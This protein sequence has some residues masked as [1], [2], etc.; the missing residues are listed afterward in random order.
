MIAPG[1]TA[2]ERLLIREAREDDLPAIVE[3][4]RGDEKGRHGDRDA[5]V[6]D[7]AP[8]RAA[9]HRVVASPD[10]ELFVAE[11]AGKVV[12]TFQL[13]LIPG[14]VAFGRMRAKVESVHVLPAWRGR[15]VGEAMMAEAVARAREAGAGIMELTS[16]KA[17]TDAH[18]FYRRLGFEQS[19]EGFK[20][21]LA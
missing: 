9:F 4:Y 11:V 2:P 8:Y 18:R 5:K 12:G 15:G 14:L 20:L 16:N 10:N 1:R 7:L 19:H 21:T 6:V 3:I 17:R 13:T